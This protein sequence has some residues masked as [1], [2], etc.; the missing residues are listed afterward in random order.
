MPPEDAAAARSRWRRRSPRRGRR[1]G[2]SRGRRPRAGRRSCR[3]S[4]GAAGLAPGTR[5]G[6]WEIEGELGRGGMGT[7]YAVR[8]ADGAY[9]QRAALKLL[10]ASA[11]RARGAC[12]LPARS[13]R[14]SPASSTRRSRACSTA[15]SLPTAAPGSPSS[16]ST[17]CRSPPSPTRRGL[18]VEA[19]LRLFLAVLG[20]VEFAHRN[21]VVH[22]DLKPSNI[23]VTA[24]GEVKLLDFGIAKLLDRRRTSGEPHAPRRAAHARSTPRPSRS[25]ASAVTT[26]TDVYALGLRALRAARRRA[27]LPGD[28]RFGAG[29]R[30]RHRRAPSRGRLRRAARGEAAGAAA[31]GS[32]LRAARAPARGRSR[33]HRRQG[34]REGAGGERYP[35]ADALARDL[36]NH[37]AGRPIDARAETLAGA[38]AQVRPPPPGRC[39]RHG[40][41][42]RGARRRAL[43]PRLRPPPVARAPRR[44]PARRGDPALP[45]R[46]LLRDR[47]RAGARARGAAARGGR[48]RRGAAR[49]RAGR[50]AARARRAAA[51]PGDRLPPARALRAGRSAARRGARA[52]R[53][54]SYGE[55]SPEAARALVALGDLDY[56][57]DDY[58]RALA[59]HRAAL[60]IFTAGGA[61]LRAEAAS[62]RFNVGTAL[63][64]LGRFEEAL[65]EERAG[66]RARAR[67]PRRRRVWRSPTSR[68]GWRSPC[69]T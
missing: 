33:R 68:P 20:A 12:P 54:G 56:W 47:P 18:T 66:A 42:R 30:A 63:R 10:A 62:A 45:G 61:A 21:L 7:V 15:A 69:T 39:R 23:L 51:H 5:L 37:L 46:A 53:N 25:P 49:D 59:R 11:D 16:G 2:C 19:R 44:G 58:E 41:A 36:E 67:A 14:S 3:R 1:P 57:R 35:S 22:R 48:S 13:A 27:P 17:A 65:A 52:A 4:S 29:A 40:G 50:P 34:A 55:R 60:A 38:G 43:R 32:T 6:P 26:A 24:A 64:Q 31:R 9:E 28:G 8:R